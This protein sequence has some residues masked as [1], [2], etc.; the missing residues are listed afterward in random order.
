MIWKN[1]KVS[2]I[3]LKILH[4]FQRKILWFLLFLKKF[5]ISEND[6]IS[7]TPAIFIYFYKKMV[8]HF[9]I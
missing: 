6:I 4:F 5:F 8:Q 2:K 7:A 9:Q 3:F 1:I